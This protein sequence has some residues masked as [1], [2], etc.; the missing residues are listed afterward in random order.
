MKLPLL[1]T[2]V[3]V[4]QRQLS[5]TAGQELFFCRAVLITQQAQGA[6]TAR[7]GFSKQNHFQSLSNVAGDR[8]Y[9]LRTVLDLW[10][11]R[12]HPCH[13]SPLPLRTVPQV[14]ILMALDHMGNCQFHELL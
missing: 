11:P 7:V 2:F 1:Q 13:L 3:V 12:D 4:S 8:I 5:C 10:L 14:P 6:P 9:F